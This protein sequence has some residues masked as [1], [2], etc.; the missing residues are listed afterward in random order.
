MQLHLTQSVSAMTRPLK[1]VIAATVLG[2]LIACAFTPP[3]QGTPNEHQIT[4]LLEK[5]LQSSS[6]DA[7]VLDLNVTD[8]WF[9]KRGHLRIICV[10]QID[11]GPQRT[12]TTGYERVQVRK[13]ELF[14]EKQRTDWRLKRVTARGFVS[15]IPAV[16]T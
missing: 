16:D 7:K 12:P 4:K 1:V 2:F 15:L 14:L 8:S 9:D 10:A 11:G 13:L 3:E 5:K 6:S